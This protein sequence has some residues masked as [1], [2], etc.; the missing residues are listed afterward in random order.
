MTMITEQAPSSPPAP[1]CSFCDKSRIEV[2]K[3]ISGPGVYICDECVGLCNAILAE[4]VDKERAELCRSPSELLAA[5]D[6]RVVG[7]AAAK[8]ALVAAAIQ[9]HAVDAPAL[10]VLLV[11]PTGS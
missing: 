10:R 5:L 1:R 7:C 9:H 3:L 4:E 6:A 8:R 2:R 11:G